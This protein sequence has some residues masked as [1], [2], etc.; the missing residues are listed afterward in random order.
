MSD[1][2]LYHSRVGFCHLEYRATGR[3]WDWFTPEC[4]PIATHFI[5]YTEGGLVFAVPYA[6]FCEGKICIYAETYCLGQKTG[7]G[8][9]SEAYKWEERLAHHGISAEL[10][11]RISGFLKIAE[12]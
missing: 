3:V 5:A 2:Y 6:V 11:G 1:L 7:T 9:I 12:L 8:K 10:I 4:L